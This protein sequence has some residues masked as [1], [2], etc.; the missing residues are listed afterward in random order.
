MTGARLALC[1]DLSVEVRQGMSVSR[2]YSVEPVSRLFALRPIP[3]VGGTW[4]VWRW[5]KR[6]R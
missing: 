3:V 4:C 6:Q 2:E 5:A 1:E